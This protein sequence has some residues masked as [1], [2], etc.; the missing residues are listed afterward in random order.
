MVSGY[1]GTYRAVVVAG[2]DPMQQNRLEVIVPEVDS[3]AMWANPSDDMQDAERPHLGSEVWIDY[4]GGDPAY[5]RWVGVV[6]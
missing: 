6:D 3:S 1:G 2:E 4:Q 5:P